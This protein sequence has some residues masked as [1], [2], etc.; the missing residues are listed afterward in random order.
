MADDTD[1]LTKLADAALANLKSNMQE[2]EETQLQRVKR[3]SGALGGM[4]RK[5][6]KSSAEM[7][8]GGA[9]LDLADLSQ[10]HHSGGARPKEFTIKDKYNADSC[11]QLLL[12]DAQREQLMSMREDFLRKSLKS[13]KS[14]VIERLLTEEKRVSEKM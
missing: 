5:E 11:E 4:M 12:T 7:A 3:F 10:K 6:E 14:K 9:G 1:G 8:D 2:I 13:S